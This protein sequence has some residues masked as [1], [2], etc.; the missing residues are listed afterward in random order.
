M[1]LDSLPEPAETLKEDSILDSTGYC[2][3]SLDGGGVRG[4]ATL[5]ILRR[6]MNEVNFERK[7]TGLGPKEPHEIFDLMG[8]T[9]T[10][11]LIAIMLGR[12]RMSVETCITQYIKLMT[13]IFERRENRSIISAFG[14]VK[15]RFSAQAL[16]DAIKEVI[17]VS[18]HSVN[19]KFEEPEMPNCKVFVCACFQKTGAITR[20]RSYATAV[21]DYS[22]TILEAALATTAAPTYFSSAAIDGSNFV[23]GALGANNPVIHVEQEARDIWCRDTGDI[24]PLVKCFVS[25]GTGRPGNRSVADKGFKHLVET[26]KK[27]SSETEGTNQEF[28]SRWREYMACG[29]CFRFNVTKGLEDVRLAEYK[30]RPLIQQ[31]TSTYL[32]ERETTMRLNE[33]ASNLRKKK[34]RPPIDFVQKMNSPENQQPPKSTRSSEKATDSEIAELLSL[35][36]KNLKTP[37]AQLTTNHLLHA[38]H[39]FSKALHFL[40]NDP[41]TPPK[42]V[43]RVCQKLLE[44]MLRLSQMTRSLSERKEHAEKAQEYGEA[45]L[46]NVEKCGD[47]CMVAQVEFLLAC[48]TAWKVYLRIKSGE[49]RI[50][51]RDGVRVLMDTRLAKLREFSNVSIEWYE[52]QAKLYLGYLDGARRGQ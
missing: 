2:L 13:C 31:A 26:L 18:G 34:H 50:A 32:D 48:V 40:S 15:P 21:S 30:E 27:E 3:L 6:T 28:E 5:Y 25:I 37:S 42:Q 17:E 12:L 16:S 24:K 22:P 20:L 11:G 14:R 52:G 7:K 8:G 10:G 36:N 46:E 51:A 45:A 47:D 23:D 41:S 44:T 38:R 39:Y 9:S 33:C 1:Q 35:G 49:D 29:R 4:L 43:A 19:E